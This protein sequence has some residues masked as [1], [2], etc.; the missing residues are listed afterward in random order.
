MNKNTHQTYT[1]LRLC[2]QN[3]LSWPARSRQTRREW[4]ELYTNCVMSS[5]SELSNIISP[6]RWWWQLQR[7]STTI[8]QR[9]RMNLFFVVLS[10][11]VL[12]PNSMI[13][14]HVSFYVT[15]ITGKETCIH[16]NNCVCVFVLVL[17]FVGLDMYFRKLY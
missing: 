15:K 11:F 4:Q 12:L 7:K 17:Y 3:I 5:A 14:I 16:P 13:D 10:S 9:Y 8:K 1:L 2:H 6:V